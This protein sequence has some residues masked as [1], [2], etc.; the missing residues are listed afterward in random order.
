[1]ADQKFVLKFTASTTLHSITFPGVINKKRPFLQL[2]QGK[3]D[4]ALCRRFF[5]VAY[6][7]GASVRTKSCWR[8]RAS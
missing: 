8:C 2:M 7:I 4:M 3:N 5:K 1:M 6:Y